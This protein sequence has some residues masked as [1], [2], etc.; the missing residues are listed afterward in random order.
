LVVAGVDCRRRSIGD[1][2]PAR[3]DG[4]F[5]VARLQVTNTGS[6]G[7]VFLGQHQFLVDGAGR[8]HSIAEDAMLRLDGE[9]AF[10]LSLPPGGTRNGTLVWDLP[11]RRRPVAIELHESAGSGGVRVAL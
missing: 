5:C 6:S 8:R 4:R 2:L 11:E 3:A 9:G 7:T 10:L 1:L